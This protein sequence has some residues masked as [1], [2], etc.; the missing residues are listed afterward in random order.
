MWEDDDVPLFTH[1]NFDRYHARIAASVADDDVPLF[2]Q[3]RFAAARAAAIAAAAVVIAR[4][5]AMEDPDYN[6][7]LFTKDSF[8][9]SGRLLMIKYRSS[10]LMFPL[11]CCLRRKKYVPA[12]QNLCAQ[13]RRL[14][15]CVGVCKPINGVHSK[16]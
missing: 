16:C 2:T 14:C 8:A 10:L 1:E 4:E 6:V 5:T 12:I 9:Y 3:E 11:L 7:S 15:S 13:Q